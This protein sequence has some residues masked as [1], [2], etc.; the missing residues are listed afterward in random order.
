MVAVNGWRLGLFRGFVITAWR[1]VPGYACYF[2][3]YEYT[4]RTL[5]SA[6]GLADS[7]MAVLLCAGAAAGLFGWGTSASLTTLAARCVCGLPSSV[8]SLCC[9]PTLLP[10]STLSAG[11]TYPFD[12]MKSRIQTLPDSAPAIASSMRHTAGEMLREQ[13]WRSFYKGLSPALVRSI[14]TNAVTFLV[15]E[16]TLAHLTALM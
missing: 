11:V 15:Y 2:L 7:N 14:P 13:G 5:S 8:T 4:K 12:V 6:L 3:A 9:G 1:D 16:S 10:S